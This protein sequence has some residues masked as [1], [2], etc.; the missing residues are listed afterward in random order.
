[1]TKA[2]AS[3]YVKA[4]IAL[5]FAIAIGSTAQAEH[6]P[7]AANVSQAVLSSQAMTT[8]SL[9]VAKGRTGSHRVGGTNSHGKRSHY[10]GGR[11]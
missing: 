10:V 4:S 6:R 9:F 11:K 5:S 3:I 7:S 1:M 8:N 2:T